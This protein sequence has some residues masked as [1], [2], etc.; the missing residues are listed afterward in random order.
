MLNGNRL[1]LP[2][3]EELVSNLV[4]LSTESD[5]IARYLAIFE[6]GRFVHPDGRTDEISSEVLGPRQ[7]ALLSYLCRHCPKPL[8]IEVGFGMGT[9][10]TV[11]LGTRMALGEP[12]EHLIFDPF[13]LSGQR[14]SVIESY[15][16]TQF[17]EAFR[18]IKKPSEIGL[19]QLIDERGKGIAGLIF[20]DGGHLFENV[21]VDFVLADQLCCEGGF[22][23]LDDARYPAIETVINYVVSNRPDYLVIDHAA[24][25]IAVLQKLGPDRREWFAFTPFKAPNRHDWRPRKTPRWRS[26]ASSAGFYLKTLLH[27]R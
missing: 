21:I 8:S 1:H 11:I 20:I 16:Q 15:L 5:A 25:S 9:S 18:R 17:A 4:A 14:G 19:G 6:N 23:V 12:F 13:G 26:A 22:I 27:P 3:S 24:P 10:A 2:G 7:V